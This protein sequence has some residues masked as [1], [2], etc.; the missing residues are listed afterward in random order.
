MKFAFFWLEIAGIWPNLAKSHQILPNL[1]EISLDLAKSGLFLQDLTGYFCS[2]GRVRV[3]RVLEMQT[4]HS[5]RRCRF[6]RTETCC[7]LIGPS[8]WAGIRSVSGG[9]AEFSG[10]GRVWTTLLIGALQGVL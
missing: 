1:V 7:R 2:C 4:R 5:T 8:V 3:A 6:L 10:S 9:L